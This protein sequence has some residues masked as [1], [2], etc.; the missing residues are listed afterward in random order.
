MLKVIK[1]AG[2]SQELYKC[3]APLVMNPDILKYNHNYPF[4]TSESFIW[5]VAFYEKKVLGF[6]PVEVR[7]KTIVINNYYV[8]NDDE[9]VFAGLLEAVIDEFQDTNKIL[10]AVVQK[11]HESFFSVQNFEIERMWSTYLKM[12]MKN[13]KN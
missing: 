5:F 9:S 1:M 3:V 6:F 4:K 13:E 8:E 12:R 7:K 10:E 11:I 2:A